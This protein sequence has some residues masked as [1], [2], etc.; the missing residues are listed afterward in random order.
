MSEKA[1]GLIYH[2]KSKD[3]TCK[4]VLKIHHFFSFLM[5]DIKPSKWSELKYYKTNLPEKL[6]LECPD[7]IDKIHYKDLSVEMFISKYEKLNK[8]VIIQCLDEICFPMQKYW[9][10]EV[11]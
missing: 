8:P 11:Y 2:L 1:D 7:Q 9:T 10:F 6:L 4:N 3:R 5:I